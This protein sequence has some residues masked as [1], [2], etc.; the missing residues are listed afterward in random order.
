MG[1][2]FTNLANELGHHLVGFS[3]APGWR[4]RSRGRSPPVTW[5]EDRRDRYRDQIQ[6]MNGVYYMYN[7]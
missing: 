6:G 4:N 7:T 1:V 2:M 5:D 3:P